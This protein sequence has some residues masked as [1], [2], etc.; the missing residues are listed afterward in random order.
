[1]SGIDPYV[2]KK[3]K[4]KKRL[5]EKKVELKS[6]YFVIEADSNNVTRVTCKI[7]SLQ[8]SQ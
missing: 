2:S 6:S 4:K 5:L 3:K 1:M 8:L 7:Y